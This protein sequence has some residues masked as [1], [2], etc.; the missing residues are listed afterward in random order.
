MVEH[1]RNEPRARNDLDPITDQSFQQ[2][3]PLR[4]DEC[5][6]GRGRGTLAPG[7]NWTSRQA[8]S[9]SPIHGPNSFPS[10]LSV[11]VRSLPSDRVIMSMS[12][13]RKEPKASVKAI[14]MPRR[15]VR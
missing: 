8:D 3:C 7:R 5:T 4:V 13:L 14:L 12:D 2:S 11:C 1:L 6:G 9:S 15:E 10:T